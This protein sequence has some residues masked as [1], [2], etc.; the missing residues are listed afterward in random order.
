MG[1]FL[2][3][4]FSTAKAAPKLET[5]HLSSAI[6]ATQSPNPEPRV[7]QSQSPSPPSHSPEL[8]HIK[9]RRLALVLW[10]ETVG[11]VLLRV[12]EGQHRSTF[13]YDSD[14]SVVRDSSSFRQSSSIE[15]K[16]D[17]QKGTLISSRSWRCRESRRAEN[18]RCEEGPQLS[19]SEPKWA[20][21]VPALAVEWLLAKRALAAKAQAEGQIK[22]HSDPQSGE[23]SGDRPQAQKESRSRPSRT[24][25]NS[26]ESSGEDCVEVVDESSL[27]VGKACASARILDPR[28][29]ELWGHKQGEPFRARVRDGL[30]EFLEFPQQGARFVPAS[31][32]VQRSSRDLFAAPIPSEGNPKNALLQGQLRLRFEGP[33]RVL[34]EI[35]LDA[36][37]HRKVRRTGQA[38]EVEIQ[39][40]KPGAKAKNSRE[41]AALS[42][43]LAQS[44]GQH[45][46]CQEATEWF[47]E[48]AKKRGWNA[49]PVLGLAWVDKRLAFHSWVVV[50][51]AG[52]LIP[53]DP[54]LAQVP[55]DAGHIQ[56][57]NGAAQVFLDARRS[58]RAVFSGED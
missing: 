23:H 7:H 12:E 51:V 25:P 34:D 14:L 46:D 36:P 33:E 8:I 18:P 49:Q 16:V 38:L 40:I 22:N 52:Q 32:E 28:T 19:A 6:S 13:R 41:F 55:A 45:H 29:V 44:R 39:Q 10:G 26:E 24:R 3:P 17:S 5:Q 9:Q 20:G 4:L 2:L 11:E 37:G 50:E 58:L 43:V 57:K 47:L 53:V 21:K 30:L 31:G 27:T 35:D 56:L 1:L 54:L 15:S 48:L 42:L